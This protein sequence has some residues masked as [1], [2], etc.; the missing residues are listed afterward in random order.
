MI[1]D[2]PRRKIVVTAAV[3]PDDIERLDLHARAM[4]RSRS[5]VNAEAVRR[6]A[7]ALDE[8]LSP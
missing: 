4:Q 7:D 6:L 1:S 8:G 2:R 5:S 3:D